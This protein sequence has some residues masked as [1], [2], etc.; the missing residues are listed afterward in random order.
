[1]P[2][3]KFEKLVRDEVLQRCLD[4]PKVLH[5]EYRILEGLKY[6]RA[7]IGKLHEEA[8]EIPIVEKATPDVID[9]IADEQSALD[10]LREAYGITAEQIAEAQKEKARKKGGFSAVRAYIIS[11]E[12]TDDSEWNEYFRAQPDKYEEVK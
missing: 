8:D 6:K 11:V 3:Y 1:M 7:L 4:D 12:V 2:V 10:A 9:E 5:T